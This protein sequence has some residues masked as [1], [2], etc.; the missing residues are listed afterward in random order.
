[1]IDRLLDGYSGLVAS[2]QEWLF[3]H[4]LASVLYAFGLSGW[5]EMAFDGLE[6]VITGLFIILLI[7]AIIVPLERMHPVE[8]WMDRGPIR[9]DILYTA[10]NILGIMPVVV[11]LLFDPIQ[12]AVG[13]AL[14]DIGIVPWT[15]ESLFPIFYQYPLIVLM[16]YV[17]VI[18]FAE[19]WRHRFQHHF[20]WWWSLHSLHHDQRQMTVWTD[21]RNHV[22]DDVLKHAW[23]LVVA[24]VIGA[25]PSSFATAVV[26]TALVEGLSHANLRV[27]F[28][29]LGDRLIVSP[30]YH[31]VHHAIEQA[32][33]RHGCNF[34]VLFPVWDMIFGT[35]CFDR[36]W[37]PTGITDDGAPPFGN[38]WWR[39]QWVGLVR[40]RR[41][42][43]RRTVPAAHQITAGADLPP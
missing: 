8:R 30:L 17:M 6:S 21:S 34:A 40:L 36:R 12:R 37:L 14:D 20:D 25:T 32:G 28:G 16:F 2:A 29:W 26:L 7:L 11:F 31:R 5:L 27:S 22:L 19:Y 33:A 23:L 4:L 24:L 39:H 13:R 41:S 18:D 10:L 35:A 3:D 15:V 9:T 1:M 38:G 43:S 42:F